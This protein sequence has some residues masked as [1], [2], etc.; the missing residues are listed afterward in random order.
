MAALPDFRVREVPPFSK[1]GVDFAG[2]L[3]VKGVSGEMEKVYIALFSCCVTRAIHL[4]LATDLS[5]TAFIRCLR[6][7]AAR[8]GTPSLIVSDNAKTFKAASKVLKTLREDPEVMAHLAKS[9]VEWRFNLEKAPWWG[10]FYERM[11]GSVKR[12]LKKVLGNAKLKFDEL[13]TILLEVEGTLNCR[14][15]TYEYTTR[16]VQRC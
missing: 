6:K 16:L 12:C 10:G 3:F 14:P 11:V 7:F 15:L 13:L 8:R 4:D 1:V 2:P 9:R 5:A